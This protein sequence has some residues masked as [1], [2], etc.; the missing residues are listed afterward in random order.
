MNIYNLIKINRY[1]KN[2]RLKFLGLWL[3]YK[4]GKRFLGVHFDPVMACNLRC[5]MCY[6]TDEE[7]VKSI[8]GIFKKED[9]EDWAKAILN[10]AMKLQIGCGTEPTL[11]KE[12][13]T[14]IR[15]GKEYKVPYISL[16]TNANLLTQEK[17]LQW[18]KEGLNEFTI[19]LHGVHKEE[20]E[21]F[22]GKASYEKFHQAL[23]YISEAKKVYPNLIL[24][25]NYTFN[26]D[27]FYSLQDFY[28]VYGK[29]GI[30]YLQLRPMKSLGNTAYQDTDLSSIANDY[31][32][33]M[34]R[35]KLQAESLGTQLITNMSFDSLQNEVNTAS[36]IREFTYC[37]ISPRYFYK[38]DFDWKSENVNCYLKRTGFGKRLRS[39]ILQSPSEIRKKERKNAL[40]YD[41]L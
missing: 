3:M 38:N 23:G 32:S 25:V 22:M 40:N 20:Y 15:L 14:I 35:I 19:S 21:E 9:L 36:Y 10:R 31:D 8:K 1:I 30:D 17:V 4:M 18:A 11:Y 26:K 34:E 33:V 28:D 39:L 41:V 12:V 16:T 24:R 13:E 37:Y 5:K 6:F 7:Y 29:Y 27:N 2:H